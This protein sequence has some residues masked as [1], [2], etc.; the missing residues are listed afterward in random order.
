MNREDL[1]A[2]EDKT[3]FV[4]SMF[5]SIAHRY[6]LVNRL[7][8]FGLDHR[9]RERAIKQLALGQGSLV[10]DIG[11]GTGDLTREASRAG[12]TCFGVD[13]SF[14]MLMAARAIHTPLIEANADSLPISS[15]SID[16]V[17]SGFALRNFT[18]ARRVFQEVARVLVPG[19]RF[20]ILE[21]DQPRNPLLRFGHQVWFNRV[22][23]VI[24][25]LFS[26]GAAYRY[27]PKSVA[28]LPNATDLETMLSASGF[29]NI[30]YHHLQGGLA[31]IIVATKEDDQR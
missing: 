25:A 28:Y 29:G 31:Q 8:T 5:D 13:L 18:D 24:G 4:R 11:C 6:D 26:E 16:G 14:E 3:D 9:W 1:P 10:L 2:P 27:L 22:V 20:V 19:G 30:N 7:I 17:V 15:L 21:I 12:L 23:P